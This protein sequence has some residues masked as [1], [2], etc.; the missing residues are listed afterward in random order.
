MASSAPNKSRRSSV[1]VSSVCLMGGELSRMAKALRIYCS[2]EVNGLVFPPITDPS[3]RPAPGAFL[4]PGV[5]CR[6][7]QQRGHPQPV[8]QEAERHPKK[9]ACP[10]Y[11]ARFSCPS[12]KTPHG[13]FLRKTPLSPFPQ[14]IAKNM[15]AARTM[16]SGI[17][18]RRLFAGKK[19]FKPFSSTGTTT[20]LCSSGSLEIWCETLRCL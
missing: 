15:L 1:H 11:T 2:H 14:K 8:H 20:I 9:T 16:Q 4:G 7:P 5:R 18:N 10:C 13:P 6:V 19:H 17:P 3:T 12:K